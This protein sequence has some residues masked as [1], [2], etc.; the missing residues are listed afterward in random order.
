M[1]KI[2]FVLSLFLTLIGTT[3]TSAQTELPEL[4]TDVN[5]PVYYSILNTRANKYA[6]YAGDNTKMTLESTLQEASFFYFTGTT[7][8]D[9]T[10]L[11]VKIHNYAT[12]NL[13][14]D[15]ESWTSDGIDW[16]IG[17][18]RSE[19]CAISTNSSL[20]G[21]TS[22]NN[23]NG[24]GYN[25]AS[26][27]ANDAGSTWIFT[28]QE[29]PAIATYNAAKESAQTLLTNYAEYIASSTTDY[30][31]PT[32]DA[33]NAL[34]N[35]IPTTDPTATADLQ[36]ATAEIN[37]A[38]TAFNNAFILPTEGEYLIRNYT[39]GGYATATSFANT[40]LVTTEKDLSVSLGGKGTSEAATSDAVWI[41]EA[42]S[43]DGTYKF[44][45]KATGL[46]VYSSFGASGSITLNAS[47]VDFTLYPSD[48]SRYGTTAIGGS[49][50]YGKWHMD[51]SNNLVNWETSEATSWYFEP[52]PTDLADGSLP[53]AAEALATRAAITATAFGQ[54]SNSAYTE[55]LATYNSNQTE[56][57]AGAMLDVLKEEISSRYFKISNYAGRGYLSA[58]DGTAGLTVEASAPT[59]AATFWILEPSGSNYKFYN[60]NTQTYFGTLTNA[61]TS[62]TTPPTMVASSDDAPYFTIYVRS[63]GGYRLMQNGSNRMNAEGTGGVLDYWNADAGQTTWNIAEATSLTVNL[64]EVGEA[65]YATAYLPFPV[66]EVSGAAV[67]T[68]NTATSDKLNMT[69]QTSI[70]AGTGVVLVS[71]D[72][73]ATATLTV[74]EAS[75]ISGENLLT[76]S[77]EAVTTGLDSYLVLGVGNTSGTIGFYAPSTSLTSIGANKAF[78]NASDVPDNAPAFALSFGD[79]TAIESVT[80]DE[81]TENA[82]IYDLS[83]RSVKKTTKGNLYFKGGKKFIA[84]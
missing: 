28:Q 69:K 12:S 59:S 48:G 3:T 53:T 60:P 7:N 73:N 27:Y 33:Y 41:L 74:G 51:G 50:Q 55:A 57:N 26:Y 32:Q 30:F 54:T 13:L 23:E 29:D 2:T 39:R 35:A 76:G 37:A 49:N 1:R 47:G 56:D 45:N 84:K 68:A 72:K 71:E 77:Y 22:W 17:S 63:A 46:Y 78:L 67:W 11:T 40:D 70:P 66:S 42:G 25:V 20:S 80:A 83:G 82:P 14:A 15:F 81:A 6:T 21:W 38:I 19:G 34:S 31:K 10:I 75:A 79:I 61:T 64:N 16:Y 4:T 43:S 9:G 52:V 36:N 8:E 65:S 62:S 5:S 44:R 18:V 24:Y 58:A